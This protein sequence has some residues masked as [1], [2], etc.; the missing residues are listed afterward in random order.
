MINID[1]LAKLASKKLKTG[2]DF[3]ASAAGK[4]VSPDAG[5]E[6]V[7][8]FIGA[9][10]HRIIVL[11]KSW[12]CVRKLTDF[13]FTQTTEAQFI[14]KENRFHFTA[15]NEH[16]ILRDVLRIPNPK[17]LANFI[18]GKRFPDKVTFE[19]TSLTFPAKK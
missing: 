1:K 14:E 6:F 11:V 17:D 4:V 5:G 9:T 10:E 12:F 3:K 13:A 8:C 16:Y 7:D 15:A 18:R 19:A 2:E